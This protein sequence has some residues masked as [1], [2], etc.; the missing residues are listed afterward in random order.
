MRAVDPQEITNYRSVFHFKIRTTRLALTLVL[1]FTFALAKADT[2]VLETNVVESKDNSSVPTDLTSY[3]RNP[4]IIRKLVCTKTALFGP[5]SNLEN[6][7]LIKIDGTN[8][9]MCPIDKN[10][11]INNLSTGNFHGT[12]WHYYPQRRLLVLADSKLNKEL[13]MPYAGPTS[14]VEHQLFRDDLET[15]VNFG[16]EEIG[17]GR[18]PDL[19]EENTNFTLLAPAR[20]GH[21]ARNAVLQFTYENGAIKSALIQRIANDYTNRSLIEY[22]YS[23]SFYDGQVPVEFTRFAVSAIDGKKTPIFTV[24]YKEMDLSKTNISDSEL[25]PKQIFGIS[26]AMSYIMWSNNINYQIT[27]FGPLKVHTA[28]EAYDR[29]QSRNKR[30]RGNSLIAV[31][32]A[33]I[34]CILVSVTIAAM[35]VFKRHFGKQ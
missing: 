5:A 1:I 7:L 8:A 24:K 23:D 10:G 9:L 25:D 11:N 6:N 13:P 32:A 14:T 21:P 28:K 2:N 27:R 12:F 22:T 20:L 33:L 34:L 16:L 29:A 4:H 26:N 17:S 3:L 18:I 30:L 31:R 15:I 35:L 19:N